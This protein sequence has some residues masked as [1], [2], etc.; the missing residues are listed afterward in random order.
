MKS[1]IIYDGKELDIRFYPDGSP[2]V[3]MDEIKDTKLPIIIQTTTLE[4][5]SI[6]M[7]FIDS[8]VERGVSFNRGLIIPYLPGARQDRI[9]KNG[10]VLY[11]LKHVA[12]EINN[13]AI[14]PLIF[15]PHSCECSNLI[16]L[17]KTISSCMIL[18]D[19][20]DYKGK[21]CGIIAPDI[22][23]TRRAINTAILLGIDSFF[24][25]AVKKRDEKTGAL[26]GFALQGISEDLKGGHF[27]VVDDICDGGG[28]FLGLADELDK[29]GV[30][31]DLY[32]THG[33]FTKGTETLL[34]RYKKIICTD[35][36]LSDKPG[37]E[38]IGIV[39]KLISGEI[40]L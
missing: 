19:C 17:L 14:Y 22:G 18:K 20:Y 26:S 38:V 6:G 30:T 4:Y 8:L 34:K 5:F 1:R 15:D 3:R 16:G 40:I 28:T 13:R 10:D 32:V 25:Q 37:V 35:S 7:C 12:K 31:A 27:L 39:E 33:L 21:Y 36:V 11:T 29:A 2:F 23:A 24:I 9:L